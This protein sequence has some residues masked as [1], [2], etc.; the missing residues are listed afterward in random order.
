M[1]SDKKIFSVI[2]KSFIPPNEPMDDFHLGRAFKINLSGVITLGE[3]TQSFFY[4]D[5]NQIGMITVNG[6]MV[7][8]KA[9]LFEGDKIDLYP[10]LEGG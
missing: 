6:Q 8:E 10:L 7:S 4:K 2:V 1:N 3:F 9:V 5:A